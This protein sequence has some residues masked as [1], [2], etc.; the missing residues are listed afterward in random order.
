MNKAKYE[1]YYIKMTKDKVIGAVKIQ[2]D[3]G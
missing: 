2:V 1:F 3:V